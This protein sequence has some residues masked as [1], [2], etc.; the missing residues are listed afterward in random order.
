MIACETPGA[1]GKELHD[2]RSGD[3]YTGILMNRTF[4]VF[5]TVKRQKLMII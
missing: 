4:K 1:V 5:Y 3:S 2:E